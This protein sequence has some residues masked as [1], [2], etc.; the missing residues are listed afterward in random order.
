M[1]PGFCRT[2]FVFSLLL[3]IAHAAV[4]Y[5]WLTQDL[6]G[7]SYR[8]VALDNLLLIVPAG[9]ILV[10]GVFGNLLLLAN[11][12]LG[13][14][15]NWTMVLAAFCSILFT[16]FVLNSHTEELTDPAR[17]AMM[18]KGFGVNVVRF[19]WL[20]VTILALKRAAMFLRR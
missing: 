14:F 17:R 15:F 19:A 3:C 4:L 20:A 6:E 13:L 2:V 1:M 7:S 9:L 10:C 11:K 16:M 5:F 8:E 18:L 12:R